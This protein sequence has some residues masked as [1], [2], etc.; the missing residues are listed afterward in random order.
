M[1]GFLSKITSLLGFGSSDDNSKTEEK[2][3]E[4]S[5]TRK[6]LRKKSDSDKRYRELN[7]K[8]SKESRNS[9]L[10]GEREKASI[11]S[12]YK[13]NEVSITSKISSLAEAKVSDT[14]SIL[15]SF[16]TKVGNAKVPEV[17]EKSDKKSENKV[18]SPE[19]ISPDSL[20]P[21]LDSL[22]NIGNL[23][24]SNTEVVALNYKMKK[25]I[26]ENQ[27]DQATQTKRTLD[28]LINNLQVLPTDTSD[29]E[30]PDPYD[31]PEDSNDS[32]DWLSKLLPILGIVAAGGLGFL[33]DLKN[34]LMNPIVGAA[35]WMYK[36][37]KWTKTVSKLIKT[38]ISAGFKG[39]KN[40][41]LKPVKYGYKAAKNALG[42]GTKVASSAAAKT[43]EK[44]AEKEVS[45]KA[46]E[47]AV[48]QS[49]NAVVKTA[50]KQGSKRAAKKA[51]KKAATLAAKKAAEKVAEKQAAKQAEKVTAKV[52]T[53]TVA[54]E[55]TKQGAKFGLKTGLKKIP[56]LGI[57]PGI[58]FAVDRLRHG[59]KVGAVLEFVSG[60]ASLL[61]LIP[62]VG[63]VAA[64]SLGMSIDA[65]LAARD[66]SAAG[67]FKLHL[68]K[69][70]YNAMKSVADF[71]ANMPLKYRLLLAPVGGIALL[72]DA[73]ADFFNKFCVLD[74]EKSRRVKLKP[75]NKESNID[76]LLKRK[77]A[78]IESI[79][80]KIRNTKDAAK[81]AELN[82]K[83]NDLN[84]QAKALNNQKKKQTEEGAG[85]AE[86][87]TSGNIFSRGFRA[88]KSTAKG[89]G[90][91]AKDVV[92]GKNVSDSFNDAVEYSQE[93]FHAGVGKKNFLDV[94]AASKRID[95][96]ANVN[97]GDVGS[98]RMNGRNTRK[99]PYKS[100]GE[101][102]SH[103]SNALAAG[104][105]PR[106]GG[107]GY[108]VGKRLH[109]YYG[110]DEYPYGSVKPKAGDVL[111]ILPNG[112]HKYGHAAYYDGNQWV[113]DFIQKDADVYHGKGKMLLY[114]L[115][116][117]YAVNAKQGEIPFYI[118]RPDDPKKPTGFGDAET[119]GSPIMSSITNSDNV[120]I[121]NSKANSSNF[122]KVSPN[123]VKLV[124]NSTSPTVNPVSISKLNTKVKSGDVT[125]KVNN[126]N[127]PVNIINGG[128]TF[129]KNGGIVNNDNRVTNIMIKNDDA[130][131]TEIS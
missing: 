105:H 80:N 122:N 73:F 79:K 97:Y 9:N 131:V 52:A 127:N 46:T 45:K 94:N 120:N 35:E 115:N 82:S 37:W 78:Q 103:V 8:K 117:N 12:R 57:I 44:I 40:L 113:S 69:S 108:E 13:N 68:G 74:E 87:G 118:K 34:G 70:A 36:S 100:V 128:N 11:D 125:S 106:P 20:T 102:A 53:K 90:K 126:N 98:S 33:A 39:I 61:N 48:K 65:Y 123:S 49:E 51:A 32:G 16:Q 130:A 55:V 114:R 41:I 47:Q 31:K 6:L 119:D 109:D 2:Q 71:F 77:Y 5:K 93:D 101:C 88:M 21:I 18:I 62:G 43:S 86:P 116:N 111:A 19:N 99:D 107:N 84:G 76:K 17:N 129:S 104:G 95:N 3:D 42:V 121:D 64:L 28:N 112:R 66:L 124:Y 38:G 30:P 60:S 27:K 110:W 56:I 54:K 14:K 10:A 81:L 89:I 91:F 59:D 24:A 75:E 4:E 67:V 15:S 72:G 26:T 50:V 22:K 1:A 83:L 25:E 92:S 96:D 23:I 58:I 7:T 85:D 29:S 63:T